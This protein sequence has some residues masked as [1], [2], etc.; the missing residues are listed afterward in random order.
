M[1]GRLARGPV[2]DL[3]LLSD[4]GV[5]VVVIG[6]DGEVVE[7]NARAAQ[8][9]PL[10]LVVLNRE[11]VS[12]FAYEMLDT[13]GQPADLDDLPAV[14]ALR[15][16]DAVS[17]VVLGFRMGHDEEPVLWLL[18]AAH[19]VHDATGELTHVVCSF[20]DVTAQRVAAETVEASERRFRQLAENAG[21]MIFR[22]RIV[23]QIAFEYVN[24]AVRTVLGYEPSDFYD[25]YQLAFDLLHPDDRADVEEH[26]AAALRDDA[27]EIDHV[28]ARMTHRDGHTVWAQFR[29]VPIRR[30][31]EVVAFEGIISD[32]TALK[33]KEAALS[34]QALHDSLTGL[35]NRTYLLDSLER[36]LGHTRASGTGLAVLYIDLDHFK[37]VNDRLGHAA[38][39]RVLTALAIRLA[40]AVRP[41]DS[42]ARIGGDEFAAVLPELRDEQH[43][44]QVAMRL[45]DALGAPV[46]LDD[47]TLVTTA[48]IGV[49]FTV[50]GEE[51]AVELLRRADVAMYEAKDR[52][53]AR[54]E[55]W[56]SRGAG[57]GSPNRP[58]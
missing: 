5:G 58:G 8:L 51:T 22:A 9:I 21:D 26:L 29:A 23:P 2:G 48:S 20:V 11:S 19:P 32:V 31:R 56:S 30:G 40:D 54:V 42:V 37:T 57:A 27:D 15:T 41:S 47:G 3:A 49:S 13:A 43:G 52:G 28:V 25:D 46:P 33:V 18:T 17:G 6:V 53:R 44:V 38:G 16:G 55:C 12:V 10:E 45:L 7:S 4:L 36:A 24:P 50:D 14:Q 35:A 34:Y 1:T 39:D